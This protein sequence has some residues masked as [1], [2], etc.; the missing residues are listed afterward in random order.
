M[1][2]HNTALVSGFYL[3]LCPCAALGYD[4]C[5][6]IFGNYDTTHR[7]SAMQKLAKLDINE[8]LTQRGFYFIFY[9]VFVRG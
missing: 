4:S 8:S 1:I 7:Y 6:L 2:T 5:E 3:S 9:G